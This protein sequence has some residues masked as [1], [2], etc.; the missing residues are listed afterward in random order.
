MRSPSSSGKRLTIGLPRLARA[1]LRR[2]VD[3]EPIAAAAIGEAQ[4]VV[5]GIGDKQMIDEILVL[6]RRRLL[7]APAATLGTIVGQRL[8]LDV[9]GVRERHHHVDCGVMKSSIPSSWV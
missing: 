7:A 5:M 3:L 6:H 4:D 1:T 8:R 2:F 9:A